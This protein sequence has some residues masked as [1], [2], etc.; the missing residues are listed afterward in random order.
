MVRPSDML[1]PMVSSSTRTVPGEVVVPGP[2]DQTLAG[3]NHSPQVLR[4][5]NFFWRRGLLMDRRIRR[6][7]TGGR[8]QLPF[9]LKYH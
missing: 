8:A 4:S 7:S 1:T 6:L 3:F 2:S 5:T 9:S